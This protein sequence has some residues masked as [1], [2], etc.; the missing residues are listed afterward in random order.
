MSLEERMAELTAA[1]NANTAAL[2]GAIAPKAPRAVKAA[3]A[4]P[5]VV[6][7][8]PAPIAAPVTARQPTADTAAPVTPAQIKAAGDDLTLLANELGARDAAIAILGEFG[9]KK[10]TEMP[11]ANV[12]EFHNRIKA[13][14]ARLTPAQTAAPSLV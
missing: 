4:A 5:A 14:I 1:L 9:V 2:G 10:M 6:A 3:S 13:A 7:A 8:A 12:P 11:A